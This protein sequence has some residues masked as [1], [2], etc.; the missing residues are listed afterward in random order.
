M[1]TREHS[2]IKLAT[3]QTE[4]ERNSARPPSCRRQQC[5]EAVKSPAAFGSNT[6]PGLQP[7]GYT[8]AT[9]ESHIVYGQSSTDQ[10]F[11]ETLK[12]SNVLTAAKLGRETPPKT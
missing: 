8:D 7:P 1:P 4:S 9:A 2:P 10:R 12:T 11:V 6:A 3:T 5:T